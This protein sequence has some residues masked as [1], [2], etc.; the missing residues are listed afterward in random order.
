MREICSRY[1]VARKTQQF[2][3]ICSNSHWALDDDP[4]NLKRSERTKLPTH[5]RSMY[6][7]PLCHNAEVPNPNNVR[8]DLKSNHLV[9]KRCP[10]LPWNSGVAAG[11]LVSP[12]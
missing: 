2:S 5:C 11:V 1:R 12:N 8:A 9:T 4:T 7:S 3:M 6:R 10:L